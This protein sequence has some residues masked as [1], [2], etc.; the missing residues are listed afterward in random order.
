MEEILRLE[1]DRSP[2]EGEKTNQGGDD[3]NIFRGDVVTVEEEYLELFQ[4]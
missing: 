1:A 2:G 3:A 4:N